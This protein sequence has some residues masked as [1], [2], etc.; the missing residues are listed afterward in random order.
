MSLSVFRDFVE[1]IK[2]AD[3]HSIMVDETSDISNKEQILFCVLWVDKNLFPYK[4]F[5][6]LY[7]MEKRDAIS[8]A[9]F[10]KD[11]N[12]RLGFDSEKVRGQCYDGCATVMGRKKGVA[13]H[14]K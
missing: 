5:L 1:S 12:L 8:I 6:G 9:N 2:N 13:T 4:I 7:E 14:K 10:I 11:I 3:F